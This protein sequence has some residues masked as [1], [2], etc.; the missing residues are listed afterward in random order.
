MTENTQ[1]QSQQATATQMSDKELNFR[2]QQQMYERQ[3]EAERQARLQAEQRAAELERMRG[4]S[5][6]EDDDSEPY[7]DKKKLAKTTS[8]V[9]QEIRQETQQDVQNAIQKALEEDRRQR[10]LEQNPDFEE[11]MS[12]AEK[13]AQLDPELARSIL[14]MPDSFER[15]KM[16]YRNIKL[17][18]VN[19]PK[20]PEQSIQQKIDAN[21]RTPFYQPSGVGTA[22]YASAGDFS[23]TGQ[24]DAY[25]KMQELQNRLR[26][27]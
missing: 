12:H 11:T 27:G 5:D 15:Q 9:K 14:S 1:D 26:L 24:R 3:L 4:S 23:Q 16:V 21:R 10:W 19:K 7:V 2:K 17:L 20:I 25:K 22:P 8:K 18:G 13:L 6:D